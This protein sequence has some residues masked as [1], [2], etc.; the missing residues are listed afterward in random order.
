MDVFNFKKL[1]SV[2]IAEGIMLDQF[3]I[4]ENGQFF[5]EKN[6]LLGTY[7]AEVIYFGIEKRGQIDGF[8]SKAK[9]MRKEGIYY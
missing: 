6:S 3:S 2:L 7:S 1:R 9:L 4:G 5:I 8:G